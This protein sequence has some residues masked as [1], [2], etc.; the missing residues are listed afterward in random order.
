MTSH[1]QASVTAGQAPDRRLQWLGVGAIVVALTLLIAPLVLSRIYPRLMPPAQPATVH[2][3]WPTAPATFIAVAPP[4]IAQPTPTPPIPEW[5]KLN[6]LTTIEFSTASIVM[7]QRTADYEEFLRTLPLVGDT[8]VPALGKDVVTDRLVMKAVGKVQLGVDLA[9]VSDVAV[10]GKQIRLRLPPP[11]VVAVE[12]LPEE[13]Q[14]FDS[15]NVWFLSQYAGMETAALEQA[16][17]QLYS[18]V[19]AN[20][21]LLKLTAEMARLQL[22][23]F[24]RKA[25]FTTVEITFNGS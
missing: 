18:E 13:S 2:E 10:T 24:L 9:Q 23:T 19:A 21:E 6:H 1:P 12:I 25:G 17:T 20:K 15:Q 3:P 7:Q 14:I 11:S 16:R 22:T 8:F 4:S 5:R